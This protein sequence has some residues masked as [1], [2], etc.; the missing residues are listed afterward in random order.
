[1]R[2]VYRLPGPSTITSAASMA[3]RA[4]GKARALSGCRRTLRIAPRARAIRDS[5]WAELPSANSARSVTSSAAEGNTRPRTASSSPPR[6]TASKKSPPSSLRAVR[7]RFPRLWPPTSPL[8]LKRKSKRAA[9]MG[10][11][12]DRARR[13]L[14]MSPGAGIRYASRRRPELPPSSAT[15]TMAVSR[16]RSLTGSHIHPSGKRASFSPRRRIGSPVPPPSATT[17]G[18]GGTR[19]WTAGSEGR[20]SRRRSNSIMPPCSF[21]VS[22]T[23][24]SSGRPP[25]RAPFLPGGR[26]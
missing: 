10:S 24:R 17:R 3:S 16:S 8:P 11:P 18:R 19:R 4:S 26:W 5:P 9:I 13:Q 22:P 7:M 25:R 1:M 12:S 14:R 21:T 15:V 2:L 6:C 20:G 23:R